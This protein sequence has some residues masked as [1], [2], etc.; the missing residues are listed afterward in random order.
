MFEGITKQVKTAI[1]D[2]NP[3]KEIDDLDYETLNL[4]TISKLPNKTIL[5]NS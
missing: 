5:K 1:D 4:A 3:V 2:A